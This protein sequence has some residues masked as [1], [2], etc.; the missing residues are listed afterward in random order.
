MANARP[1]PPGPS[2]SPPVPALS[3]RPARP[4]FHR[5][6]DAIEAHLTI[7]FTAL[8]VAH[9]IQGRTGLPIA[10]VPANSFG[11]AGGSCSTEGGRPGW[12]LAILPPL[13]SY[14]E[15]IRRSQ[16]GFV[17][18]SGARRWRHRTGSSMGLAA[19]TV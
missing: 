1:S 10:N 4:I 6:R 13:T 8:A 19:S 14:E 18:P 15:K 17:A 9:A 11:L 3:M 2:K 16:C 5:T 7:V 12:S